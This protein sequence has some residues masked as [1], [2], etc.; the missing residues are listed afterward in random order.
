MFQVEKFLK[1]TAFEVEFS[2]DVTERGRY[3]PRVLDEIS[4]EIDILEDKRDTLFSKYLVN[5][6]SLLDFPILKHYFK[7]KKKLHY[8]TIYFQIAKN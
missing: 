5:F 3:T 8:N 6:S 7:K 4:E 2:N 1:S